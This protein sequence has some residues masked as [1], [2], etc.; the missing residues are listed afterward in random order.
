MSELTFKTM[1]D[2]PPKFIL[3]LASGIKDGEEVAESYGYSR[4]QWV[5]MR[6]FE[7]LKKIVE[8][9][10]AELKASGWSF[11]AKCSFIAEELLDDLYAKSKEPDASF[12]QILESLK[13]T[14]K[15]AGFEAPA[16]VEAS[17]GATFNITIDLGGGKMI[18]IGA[19]VP[20]KEIIDVEPETEN[21]G[22]DLGEIPPHLLR[23]GC[24]EGF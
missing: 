16:K 13:L 20:P 8:L 7:P 14:A 15:A 12:H 24:R 22:L 21:E 4:D 3:E 2:L 6:E 1:V 11:R 9:K 17:T 10:K 5:A 18:T 23:A 19:Q